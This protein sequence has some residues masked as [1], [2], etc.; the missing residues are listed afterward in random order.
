M[1]SAAQVLSSPGKGAQRQ[2]QD[3]ARVD[4]NQPAPRDKLQQ[5]GWN[6]RVEHTLAGFHRAKE[7]VLLASVNEAKVLFAEMH[8]NGS[9][10]VLAPI[11][12]NEMGTEISVL[13]QDQNGCMQSRQRFLHRLGDIS[14]Q[15]Q[16][17]APQGRSVKDGG[18]KQIVLS[19]SKEYTHK[20]G[21]RAAELAPGVAA[22][23]RLH[24][25]TELLSRA[26]RGSSVGFPLRF[27]HLP[28]HG[29]GARL[30]AMDL[31]GCRG[32][33]LSVPHSLSTC[34]RIH[35]FSCTRNRSR[36]FKNLMTA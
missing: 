16:S 27:V 29:V 2:R 30:S 1:G 15:C 25:N 35:V 19:P 3:A 33:F 8:S 36:A 34:L 23:R 22:R 10:A 17:T 32:F 24:C 7:A 26:P 21:W 6:V 28:F 20:Q 14:V 13:V 4:A 12:V 31:T 9:L 11:N 18:T 5:D